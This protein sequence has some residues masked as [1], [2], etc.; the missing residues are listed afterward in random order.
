V[1]PRSAIKKATGLD[2]AGRAKLYSDISGKAAL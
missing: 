2:S 1:I